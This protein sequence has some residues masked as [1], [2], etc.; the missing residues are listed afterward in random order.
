MLEVRITRKSRQI[1]RLGE[2]R[3]NGAWQPWLVHLEEA[4]AVVIGACDDASFEECLVASKNARYVIM[5]I[6]GIVLVASSDLCREVHL[7]ES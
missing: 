6:C 1:E 4:K 5:T 3:R 7:E 2:T